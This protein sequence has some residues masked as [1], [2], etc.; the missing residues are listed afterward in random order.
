M[1]DEKHIHAGET[2]GICVS[3]MYNVHILENAI[4]KQQLAVKI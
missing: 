3:Y 1:P 4:N 2:L